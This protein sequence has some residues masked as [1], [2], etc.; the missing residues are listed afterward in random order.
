[1]VNIAYKPGTCFQCR[2]QIDKGSEF[3]WGLERGS[4]VHTS[5]GSANVVSTVIELHL[6]EQVRDNSKSIGEVG[7]CETCGL[8]YDD[9]NHVG[10]QPAP[11]ATRE[12]SK[13][14]TALFDFATNSTKSGM[15][16]AVA[17]SGKTTATEEFCR[18][19]SQDLTV[20]Y[21]VFNKKN[22]T[23]AQQRMPSN[24]HASTFHSACWSALN[25]ALNHPQID[26]KKTAQ[27]IEDVITDRQVRRK[28]SSTISKLVGLAKNA[29]VGVLESAPDTT[30]TYMD[31]IDWHAIDIDTES[32]EYADV[33][34]VYKRVCDW[35][36]E[37]L[38]RSREHTYSIDFDDMLY[39]TLALD[40]SLPQYDVVCVDEAQDTNAV[41][42]AILRK[43]V[44]SNG[45]VIAVGD[46]R[47][48]IYGF[49]GAD[50]DSMDII[51]DSFEAEEL[52]LSINYRCSKAVVEYAQR[53][54]PQL[55]AWDNAPDGSVDTLATFDIIDFLPTDYVICRNTAPLID[56][57][58][59]IL[60]AGRGC[61]VLGRDIGQGLVKT[62]QMVQAHNHTGDDLPSFSASLHDWGMNQ[63]RLLQ[64]RHKEELV[65]NV[66][67]KVESINY[68]IA[69]MPVD[70][71]VADLITKVQSLFD[72]ANGG[73][74]TLCTVHKA[75]GSEAPR[76]F[77]L[78]R[79]LMPSKWAKQEWQA[80]QENNLIYV[81]YTR[82][83][84]DL[85]F[86]TTE[87]LQ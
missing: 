3:V 11:V 2:K 68:A 61:R 10:K 80:Q 24:V 42:R 19:L 13:Y 8:A 32:V 67:D 63:A 28:W 65:Q 71:T 51:R 31:L 29:G 46:P 72:D 66:I 58:M 37:V 62:I 4:R 52:P 30:Q 40:I 53:Y 49:R 74:T 45:R 22:A 81:A 79:D 25:R 50:A 83:Q 7:P 16:Y 18:R 38:A 86:I 48:A 36:S 47:Q 54:C 84:V 60:R 14:Q 6:F 5:C 82:A 26:D 12:W 69:G 34:K 70:A 76:V 78:N 43:M 23:E 15:V 64:R 59:R 41:Q 55:E 39:M 35:T 75:K 20:K 9:G 56:L 73:L 33:P 17:G 85:R 21:L 1:M 87:G 44:K 57:A 27:M 77:I